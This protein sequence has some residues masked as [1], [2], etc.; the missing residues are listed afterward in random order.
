MLTTPSSLCKPDAA[1]I[2]HALASTPSATIVIVQAGRR[3]RP[4]SPSSSSKP[5][6]AVIIHA[7]ARHRRHLLLSCTTWRSGRPRQSLS[8]PSSVA[9]ASTPEAFFCALSSPCFQA[10]GEAWVVI[11]ASAPPSKTKNNV[12]IEMQHVADGILIST[13]IEK[14]VMGR[15]IGTEYC[16][17]LDLSEASRRYCDDSEFPVMCAYP[18]LHRMTLGSVFSA[19]SGVKIKFPDLH[20]GAEAMFADLGLFSKISIRNSDWHE[21]ELRPAMAWRR[22][23]DGAIMKASFDWQWHEGELRMTL[24]C[25]RALTGMKTNHGWHAY[26]KEPRLAPT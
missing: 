11:A 24:A 10:R 16:G 8:Q 3:P 4:R 23:P 14:V 9:F 17:V 6:A 2:I 21:D 26:E 15:K 7:L 12:D 22:A 20:E 25:R 13:E 5:D 18:P 19:V 1:V